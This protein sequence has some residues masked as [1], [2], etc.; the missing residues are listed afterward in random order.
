MRDPDLV[1]RAQRAATALERAWHRWR[2]MHGLEADPLPPVSS[3][4]GYSLEEP[5]GQPRVVFGVDAEEA[6]QL[7]AILDGHDCT[8]RSQAS[9]SGLPGVRQPAQPPGQDREDAGLVQVPAQAA[10]TDDELP[11]RQ[12][13]ASGTRRPSALDPLVSLDGAPRPGR[14]ALGAPAAPAASA[15]GAFADAAAL[16]DSPVF[17]EVA[18]AR[19]AAAARQPAASRPAGRAAGEDAAGTVPGAHGTAADSELSRAGAQGAAAADAPGA[20]AGAPASA[21]TAEPA[22]SPE[23][24]ASPESAAPPEHAAPHDAVAMPDAVP[25]QEDGRVPADSS[26]SDS[27]ADWAGHQPE[28]PAVPAFGPGPQ[29]AAYLDEGP[30]S[31]PLLDEPDRDPSAPADNARHRRLTRG[32]SLPRLARPKRAG[33]QPDHRAAAP[34]AGTP[35]VPEGPADAGER[36]GPSS[37]SADIASWT[38]GELPGQ[39][40]RNDTVI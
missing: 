20:G 14:S 27:E 30:E 3:Y 34:A 36:P 23:P 5:W 11:A 31:D 21:E 19:R 2:T 25:G 35:R 29:L 17:R 15:A 13:P 8:G 4:V 40:A 1:L 9:V 22:F 28:G 33:S 7:T 16:Q 26:W 38:A 37:R 39:A 24:A 10:A 6:E 12:E 32:H 18:A